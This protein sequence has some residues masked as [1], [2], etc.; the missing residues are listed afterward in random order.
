MADAIEVTKRVGGKQL[1]IPVNAPANNKVMLRPRTR[2][3]L[4][5]GGMA[6]QIL[7]P[8]EADLQKLR[9]EVER[10]AAEAFH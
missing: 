7:G 3:T 8:S 10:M 6:F 1:K 4:S 9:D 5:L 2:S